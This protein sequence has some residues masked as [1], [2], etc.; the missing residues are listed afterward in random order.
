MVQPAYFVVHVSIGPESR[1]CVKTLQE[2]L[3]R[4]DPP[5]PK[6]LLAAT[7][8]R[9]LIFTAPPTAAPP[10]SPPCTI[11]PAPSSGRPAA[12]PPPAS[13]C[14]KATSSSPATYWATPSA[15]PS[16]AAPLNCAVSSRQRRCGGVRSGRECGCTNR[17]HT[18]GRQGPVLGYQYKIYRHPERNHHAHGWQR[19]TP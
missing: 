10:R 1:F 5:M 16:I 2:A 13:A 19:P 9:A 15:S 4:Y 8:C 14:A 3:Y 7:R 17:P 12:P 6:T 18:F 11:P